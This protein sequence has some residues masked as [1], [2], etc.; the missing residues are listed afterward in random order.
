MSGLSSE[1][2]ELVVVLLCRCLQVFFYS[3]NDETGSPS[4]WLSRSARH[5]L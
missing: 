2:N 1:S 4:T 5:A 3:E